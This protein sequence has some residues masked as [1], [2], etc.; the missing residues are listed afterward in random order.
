MERGPQPRGIA[1]DEWLQAIDDVRTAPLPPSDAVTLAEFG[2]MLGTSRSGAQ[3]RMQRLV[4]AG[5]ATVTR[6]AVRRADGGVIL[7]PAYVLTKDAN[8]GA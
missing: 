3:S 1:R 8:R 6:K 7:V 4:L 2:D 5:R